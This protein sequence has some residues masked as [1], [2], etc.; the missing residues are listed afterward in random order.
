MLAYSWSNDG[1]KQVDQFDI[2]LGSALDIMHEFES[3]V[4]SARVAVLGTSLS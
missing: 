2:T 3:T 4:S 1:Y